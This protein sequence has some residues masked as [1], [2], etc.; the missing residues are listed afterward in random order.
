MEDPPLGS[1]VWHVPGQPE[2]PAYAK[3]DG[4]SQWVDLVYKVVSVVDQ[5]LLQVAEPGGG[6]YKKERKIKKNTCNIQGPQAARCS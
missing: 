5:V 3:V 6:E 4:S 2:V 1:E